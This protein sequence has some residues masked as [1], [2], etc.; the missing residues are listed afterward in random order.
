MSGEVILVSVQHDMQRLMSQ[1]TLVNEESNANI[2]KSIVSRITDDSIL[3]SEG[4]NGPNMGTADSKY[5]KMLSSISKAIS[6]SGKK[7]ILA[8]ADPRSMVKTSQAQLMINDMVAVIRFC[9]ESLEFENMPDNLASALALMNAGEVPRFK[10]KRNLSIN[11]KG[12]VQTLIENRR[13][14]DKTHIE[15]MTVEAQN[16]DRCFLAGNAHCQ[17]IHI[18]TGWPLERMFHV[19]PWGVKDFYMGFAAT[20]LFPKILH[21]MVS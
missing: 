7:P 8:G 15:R 21:E 19:R 12:A 16:H 11:V 9:N 17:S 18:K 6:V 3:F 2:R 14:F 1:S 10:L 13:V 5:A 4:W 20:Q